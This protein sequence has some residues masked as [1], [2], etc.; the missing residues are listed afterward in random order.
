M[1]G[2]FKYGGLG[3]R[4]RI[5]WSDFPFFSLSAEMTSPYFSP[6]RKAARLRSRSPS[7]GRCKRTRFDHWPSSSLDISTNG[8]QPC[9]DFVYSHKFSQLYERLAQAKP[10]LIQGMSIILNLLVLGFI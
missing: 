3:L 10:V 9:P 1:Y 6:R 8:Q 2:T 7:E 4:V 5:T